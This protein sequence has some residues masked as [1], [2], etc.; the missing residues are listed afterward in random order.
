MYYRSISIKNELLSSELKNR[1]V[2]KKKS[3]SWP[4]KSGAKLFEK[5]NQSKQLLKKYDIRYLI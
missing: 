5:K 1:F 4:D 2:K 3:V